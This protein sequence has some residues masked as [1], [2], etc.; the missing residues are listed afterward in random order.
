MTG[1]ATLPAS[2]WPIEV[3]SFLKRTYKGLFAAP[4]LERPDPLEIMAVQRDARGMAHAAAGSDW[5]PALGHLLDLR[6]HCLLAA[7]ALDPLPA[8][9]HYREALTACQSALNILHHATDGTPGALAAWTLGVHRLILAQLAMPDLAE[10]ERMAREAMVILSGISDPLC[11]AAEYDAHA[12]T[13]L[14]HEPA[15]LRARLAAL[16]ERISDKISYYRFE[17]E[18]QIIRLERAQTAVRRAKVITTAAVG[19]WGLLNLALM[20]TLPLNGWLAPEVPWSLPCALAV[21]LL[22]W[23]TWDRPVKGNLRFF[24]WVRWMKFTTLDRLQKAE[25]DLIDPAEQ[26]RES[27]ARLLREARGDRELLAGY[28]LFILPSDV[29]TVD[30]AADLAAD[31]KAILTG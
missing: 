25:A 5:V 31:G 1:A 23:F 15:E 12:A 20:A 16:P 11:S 21:P 26:F 24:D 9:R 3:D 14:A 17:G 22:W 6:G 7:A 10:T 4:W 8:R 30:I 28:Y 29:D 19:L 18:Q 13:R 2:Q 27:S